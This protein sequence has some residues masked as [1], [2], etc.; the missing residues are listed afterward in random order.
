[1]REKTDYVQH[2]RIGIGYVE[3][4]YSMDRPHYH[5]TYEIFFVEKGERN[6]TIENMSFHLSAGDIV[7]I[8]PY[9]LHMA[10]CYNNMPCLR[11]TMNIY[12]P[13]I[14][15]ILSNKELDRILSGMKTTVIHLGVKD[16]D[17]ALHILERIFNYSNRKDKDAKKLTYCAVFEIMDFVCRLKIPAPKAERHTENNAVLKA[18]QYVHNNYYEQVPLDFVAKYANMSKSNFWLVFKK[19]IGETFADY[20]NHVRVSHVHRLLS[21]TDLPLNEIARQTG[22]SSA[23]YMT[24]VF[25]K[26]NGITPSELR[27]TI[28]VD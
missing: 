18:L 4:A 17:I 19:A 12:A 14:G 25:K 1:M 6:I 3:N 24:S 21:E 11:Y 7:I 23:S 28:S 5:D 9:T 15:N 13:M 16:F 20:L 26:F 22:F 27:K 2:Q 8:E 10:E